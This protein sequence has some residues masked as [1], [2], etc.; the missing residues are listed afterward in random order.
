MSCSVHNKSGKDMSALTNMVKQFYPYAQKY[1]GFDKPA[2][3]VYQSDQANAQDPLGK[4]AHYQPDNY[5]VT[6]Y[7]D[8]RHPKDLLRSLAHELVHHAQNC[9]GDLC[10]DKMGETGDGYAQTNNHLRKMEQEAYA[11]MVMRDWEDQYK[12]KRRN[13][14]NETNYTNKEYYTMSEHEKLVQRI[15]AEVMKQAADTT[16]A[17][18]EKDEDVQEEGQSPEDEEE[19]D[20]AA[21]GSR[22]G[23]DR[24]QEQCKKQGKKMVAG[25]CVELDEEVEHDEVVNENGEQVFAPNH[26]CVHHGGVQMNGSVHMAEAVNHN[27]NE[28][29]GRVTHYDMKLADGTVLENVAAEDIQVTNASLAE[30]HKGKRDDDKKP[31]EDGDGVPDWADKKKGD[32]DDDDEKNESMDPLQETFQRRQEKLFERLSKWSKQ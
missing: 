32:D 10:A 2:E 8:G 15:V 12:S 3:I 20:E 19:L 4:T 5:T 29:L 6:L 24:A 28:E 21:K 11:S 17:D 23:G 7:V 14:L 13:N 1:L 27:F 26:Y 25:K 16:E 22:Q 31:D 30:A 9:R 18:K